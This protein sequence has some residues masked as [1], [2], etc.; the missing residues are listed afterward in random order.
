MSDRDVTV[1]LTSTAAP[2]TR[3]CQN[4]GDDPQVQLVFPLVQY[5]EQ[6]QLIVDIILEFPFICRDFFF[7]LS[8]HEGE[9]V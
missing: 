5:K 7:V 2:E 1:H 8:W 6:Q 4:T 3:V 9:A